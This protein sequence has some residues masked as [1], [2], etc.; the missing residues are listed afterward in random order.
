MNQGDWRINASCRDEEPDQLFVRGAEQRKAKL[1]C[2]GCPVRMEC[3][4][5]ALDNKIEFGVW[6]GMTERERRALLR[7]RPDVDSWHELL[8]NARQE[9][10]E[11]TRVS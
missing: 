2:L 1:V 10:V 3:L 9:H 7:R 5:E 11:D 8:D 4:A 6:G